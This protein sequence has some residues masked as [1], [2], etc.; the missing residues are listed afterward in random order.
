[1]KFFFSFL[2]LL[3]GLFFLSL[4]ATLTGR[5]KAIFV[6]CKGRGIFTLLGHTSSFISRCAM[7]QSDE[8]HRLLWIHFLFLILFIH[9][10]STQICQ[11]DIPDF[12]YNVSFAGPLFDQAIYTITASNFSVL[13]PNGTTVFTFNV[14]PQTDYTR[15]SF[16]STSVSGRALN[17]TPGIITVT[18]SNPSFAVTTLSN[19]SYALVTNTL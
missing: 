18:S 13:S 9:C 5:T 10:T 1:M 12:F 8:K 19:G 4:S 17:N 3:Q 15:P 16:V 14:Q 2:F 7:I 11:N 6:R